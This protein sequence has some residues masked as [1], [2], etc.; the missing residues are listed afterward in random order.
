MGVV[1]DL[2][3]RITVLV[4]GKVIASDMPAKIRANNAVR[5]AYLGEATQ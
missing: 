1:F 5:E 2:A 3:D 4:H